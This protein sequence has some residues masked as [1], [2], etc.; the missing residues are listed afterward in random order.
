MGNV[1]VSRQK[2]MTIPSAQIE[3]GKKSYGQKE[4]GHSF[5]GEELANIILARKN[6]KS[7]PWMDIA[8]QEYKRGVR[9]IKGGKHNQRILLYHSYTTLKATADE[10]PWCSS[11]ANYCVAQAGFEPTRSAA[12]RSWLNFGEKIENPFY[13]CIVVFRRGSSPTAGHVAFYITTIGENILC[14]GGN[15]SDTW[16][17]AFYPKKNVLGYR[18]V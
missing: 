13:S 3:L 6:F 9:E 7:Y 1:H 16:T 12:A 8:W 11:A 4:V 14:L 17:V 2:A 5:G 18:G 15:Q 10:V